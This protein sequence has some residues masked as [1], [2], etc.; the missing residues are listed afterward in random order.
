MQKRNPFSLTNILKRPSIKG[1]KCQGNSCHQVWDKRR[2]EKG[3]TQRNILTI[4]FFSEQ[5]IFI[6]Y[7]TL[8][9]IF[10][11]ASVFHCF[12]KKILQHTTL[13]N[14]IFVA[15]IFFTTEVLVLYW[16][17]LLST[18]EKKAMVQ[19]DFFLISILIFPE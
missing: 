11:G 17:I 18:I 5:N 9:I 10:Q 7:F 19:N 16:H 15:N 14:V 3:N 12:G 8:N 13:K 6:D 2:A 4:A 1:S